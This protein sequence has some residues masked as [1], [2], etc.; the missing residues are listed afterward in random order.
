MKTVYLYGPITGKTYAGASDWRDWMTDQLKPHGIV[1]Y[2]PLRAKHYLASM[3]ELSGH[4]RDYAHMGVL[5]TQ[6]GVVTRDKFDVHRVDMLAGNFLD[7]DRVSI[8]SM[9]EQAWAHKE[10]KPIAAAVPKEPG[11]PHDHMFFH[12]T[13]GFPVHSL[14]DLRD[15]II[16]VLG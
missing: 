2:S 4:G 7:A 3:Q 8:G 9:M 14:D 11:H 16:A 13:L 5:S 12:G 15:I 10:H 6:Q 1:T